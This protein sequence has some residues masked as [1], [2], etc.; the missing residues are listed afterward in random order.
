MK[1]FITQHFFG[2]S[3]NSLRGTLHLTEYEAR[4]FLD[5]EGG[6]S[7]LVW[8]CAVMVLGSRRRTK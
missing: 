2:V 3:A 6:R 8:S 1:Q 4:T 5:R 7:S